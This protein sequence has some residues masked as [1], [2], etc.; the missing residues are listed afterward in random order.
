MYISHHNLYEAKKEK[1]KKI[2]AKEKGKFLICVIYYCRFSQHLPN[3]T[4]TIYQNHE[5]FPTIW[6]RRILVSEKETYGV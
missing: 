3:N 2:E 6:Q 4:K 5:I 1:E